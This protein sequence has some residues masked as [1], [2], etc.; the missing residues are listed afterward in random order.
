MLITLTPQTDFSEQKL[1]QFPQTR[2]DILDFKQRLPRIRIV[3][4]G[5]RGQIRQGLGISQRTQIPQ[6][7]SRKIRQATLPG[8]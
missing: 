2:L 5:A 1:D 4:H 6:R 7:V 3:Q 8:L